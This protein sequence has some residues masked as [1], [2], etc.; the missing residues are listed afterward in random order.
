MKNDP[1]LPW[2]HP[3]RAGPKLFGTPPGQVLRHSVLLESTLT[4]NPKPFSLDPDGSNKLCSFLRALTDSNLA[5]QSVL[6]SIKV[7]QG[8]GV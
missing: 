3:G 6:K 4:L 1:K 8:L 5:E 2:E 7:L